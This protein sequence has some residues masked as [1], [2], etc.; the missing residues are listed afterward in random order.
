MGL[1]RG[2][3]LGFRYMG[4][5]KEGQGGSIVNIAS[6]LVF[7]KPGGCPIHVGTKYFTVGLG[8][9]FGHPSYFSRTGV[10]VIT[11]CPGLTRT[12]MLR[13][14]ERKGLDDYSGELL[15][16]EIENMPVQRSVE[17][18]KLEIFF[19][20]FVRFQ[21]RSCWTRLD[22][23]TKARKAWKPVGVWGQWAYLRN[24]DIDVGSC[25]ERNSAGTVNIQETVLIINVVFWSKVNKNLLQSCPQTCCLI[26]YYNLFKYVSFICFE[27][28]HINW[29]PKED[30]CKI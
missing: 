6:A 16:D 20:F 11:L 23:G 13:Q 9:S 27:T 5:D 4:K 18:A 30:R 10:R 28:P 15:R 3:L 1:A 8:C 21:T 12:P 14:L 19:S 26:C 7:Q 24:W 29:S 2:T 22:H 17:G 25:K